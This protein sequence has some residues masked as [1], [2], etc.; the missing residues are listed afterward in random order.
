M[1]RHLGKLNSKEKDYNDLR[2]KL[3][4]WYDS[5]TGQL[6]LNQAKPY[7]DGVL[8]NLFGYHLLQIGHLKGSNLLCNS[9]ISHRTVIE[10]HRV[11]IND[12]CNARLLLSELDT[13]PIASDSV[14]V[15]IL[16]HSLEIHPH[17]HR[18]LR[19]IDRIL[20]PEGHVVIIGFNP[21]SLWGLV[22]L[23]KRWFGRLPWHG[24][25]LSLLRLKDWLQLLGFEL[26]H[27]ELYFYRPPLAYPRVMKKLEGIEEFGRRY[28]PVLGGGY[29][30]VAKKQ[31]STMT[32][33]RPHWRLRRR[34]NTVGVTETS[35]RRGTSEKEH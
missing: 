3:D 26:V 35:A 10:S 11:A 23:V 16:P 27:N 5:Y 12:G 4:E 32:P 18:I 1:F 24:R 33:I 22:R 29:V 25:F 30:L 7:V 6:F 17:P 14:D 34:F 13:L 2:A 31:V 28:W 9:R 8:S 15:V 19:E 21:S 20:V